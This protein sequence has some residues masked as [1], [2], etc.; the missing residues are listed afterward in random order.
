MF[1]ISS[2]CIEEGIDLPI[3]IYL[4]YKTKLYVIRYYIILILIWSNIKNEL[5]LFQMITT[6]HQ[7]SIK[8]MF[9]SLIQFKSFLWQL[10]QLMLQQFLWAPSQRNGRCD[11]E[12]GLAILISNDITSNLKIKDIKDCSYMFYKFIENI[13][14]I[15]LYS[16]SYYNIVYW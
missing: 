6:S 12:A 3:T 8:G 13:V 14:N 4:Q 1:S 7:L 5:W 10:G 9:Q 15:I 2:I 16:V 11:T